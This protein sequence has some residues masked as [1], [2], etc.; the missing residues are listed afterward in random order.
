MISLT[1]SKVIAMLLTGLVP[2]IMGLIPWKAGKFL[3]SNNIRHQIIVSSLLC[4]G[5][6]VLLGVSILH[7]LPEVRE[8]L[9][10]VFPSEHALAETILCVGFFMIYII[11]EFVH[12]GC[13]RSLQHD[14]CEDDHTRSIAVHR[15]FS[16]QRTNCDAGE[17][18][19]EAGT[20][21]CSPKCRS[22][23]TSDAVASYQTPP[24]I[25][26]RERPVEEPARGASSSSGNNY[27]TFSS[28]GSSSSSSD[29]EN[30]SANAALVHSA[31]E[32]HTSAIRDFLTV[33]ALSLHAVF[34]GLAVGLEDSVVTVW[35]LYA[36]VAMHKYIL[37]FCVGLELF[38]AK[39]NHFLVNFSYILVFAIMSPLG[40][41][42]GI[43]VTTLLQEN[44]AGYDATV[45]ILQGLAAG[46]LLY[47]VVFEVLQREKC[48]EK[49]PG[50]IQLVFVLAGFVTILL[51]VRYGP[52]V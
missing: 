46:T 50:L 17:L 49:V 39:R 22:L 34:E 19:P 31:G 42:I 40:I 23:S 14:H 47:V 27:N 26:E 36:A 44:Q 1:A 20:S 7:M 35:T 45:G 52:D 12:F 28:G 10:K 43:A 4:Y 38:T 37:A 5:G 13:D 8:T 41:G 11:E 6:G 3:D 32:G 9:E 33:L 2:I 21:E 24:A 51:F 29:P 48:K 18:S 30:Q 16:T 25:A 15:A